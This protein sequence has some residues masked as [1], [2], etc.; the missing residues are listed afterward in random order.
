MSQTIAF[1]GATGDTAGFCLATCLNSSNPTYD[2]RA[3]A[4]TPQKLLKS[5]LAKGVSQQTLDQRL[6]IVQ[7]DVKDVEVMKKTLTIDDSG[8]VVDKIVCGIGKKL[9]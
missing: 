5:L 3:L 1:L 6:T 8:K 9:S 2:C 4:R 7:G